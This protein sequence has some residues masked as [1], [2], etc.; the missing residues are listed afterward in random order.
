MW[1]YKHENH[2]VEVRRLTIWARAVIK[3]D[4]PIQLRR[5]RSDIRITSMPA[6]RP[7]TTITGLRR[8]GGVTSARSVHGRRPPWNIE[9]FELL[10]PLLHFGGI[11][12]NVPFALS[13]PLL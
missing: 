6:A 5:A 9:T 4:T 10:H 13:S 12:D 3:A 11:Y 1:Q 8:S 2:A 7:P